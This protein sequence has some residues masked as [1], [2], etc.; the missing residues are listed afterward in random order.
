MTSPARICAK[1]G[2]YE[3]AGYPNYEDKNG[4]GYP[5][6]VDVSR[7][8]AVFFNNYPDHYETFRPKLD[9]RFVPAIQNE[10]GEYIANA[11]YK[12]IPGAVLRVGNLPRSADTGV[13]SVDDMIVQA[14]GRGLS[15]SRGIWTTQNCSE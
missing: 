6:K 15:V 5:D 12:D 13:H 1:V 9:G 8:L 3:T 14:A 10:K 4:D 7:R 11:A 2:V